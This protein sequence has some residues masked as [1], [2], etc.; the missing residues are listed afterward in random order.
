MKLIYLHGAIYPQK[1]N[2]FSSKIWIEIE[3]LQPQYGLPK[4]KLNK[5]AILYNDFALKKQAKNSEA[6]VGIVIA[7]NEIIKRKYNKNELNWDNESFENK[8]LLVI[9]TKIKEYID[10]K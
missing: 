3:N 7:K 8:V 9:N 6:L 4:I 10:N 5:D 2:R 1:L